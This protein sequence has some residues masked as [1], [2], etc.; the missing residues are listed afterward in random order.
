MAPID[1]RYD[2]VPLLLVALARPGCSHG[3][4][5]TP[6]EHPVQKAAPFVLQGPVCVM[7]SLADIGRCP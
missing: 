3:A 2:L 4:A 1:A 6:V 7:S 5:L